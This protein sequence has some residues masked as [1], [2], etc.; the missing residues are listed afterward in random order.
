MMAQVGEAGICGDENCRREHPIY[1][2]PWSSSGLPRSRFQRQDR[3][4]VMDS[5]GKPEDDDLCSNG[6]HATEMRW[7]DPHHKADKTGMGA[8]ANSSLRAVAK[9]RSRA[10]RS[11]NRRSVRKK[12]RIQSLLVIFR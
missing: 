1:P 8:R 12:D 7:L 11:S 3:T 2:H 5:R 9:R 4:C 6:F 10:L